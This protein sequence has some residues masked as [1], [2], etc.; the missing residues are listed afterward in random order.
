MDNGRRLSNDSL[1]ATHAAALYAY[2]LEQPGLY[3]TLNF[4]MFTPG[5]QADTNLKRFR[6]YIKHTTTAAN[7][8]PNFVGMTYR[9]TERIFKQSLYKPGDRITWQAFSSSS[10]SQLAASDFVTTLPGHKLSGSL[11]I[12]QVNAAKKIESFSAIPEEQE[13][14][15]LPNA[16]FKVLRR[17]VTQAEKVDALDDLSAYDMTD[18]NVYVLEQL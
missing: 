17:L 18:L 15:I 13:V 1:A 12:L 14:L 2:T 4:N 16:Q 11:F 7:A 6:D 5:D 3:K 9:G 10:R 8:L